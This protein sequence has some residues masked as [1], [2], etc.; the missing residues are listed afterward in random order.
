MADY[1]IVN[2]KEVEDSATKFDLSP[3]LEARFA[4]GPLGAERSGISY[5]R[6]APNFRVPFAHSHK[7]QEEMYVLLSGSA[8]VKLEDDVV[9]LREWDVLRVSPETTRSFEAG[10]DGA[11]LLAFGAGESGDADT[12]PGWWS[13]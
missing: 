1:K 2:L 4:R 12:K 6:I 10:P 11:E 9:E 8:R 7:G 3:N 13:D 5:Q